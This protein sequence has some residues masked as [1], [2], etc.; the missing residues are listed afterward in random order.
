MLFALHAVLL[1]LFALDP[2]ESSRGFWIEAAVG[3]GFLGMGFFIIQFA[4]TGRFPRIAPGYGS[5]IVLQFHRYA[6]IAGVILILLHPVLLIAA[7]PAYLRFFDPSENLFRALGM[8]AVTFALVGILVSSAWGVPSF[9]TYEQWRLIHAAFALALVGIGM[10][11]GLQVG[12]YLD[13]LWKQI[14]WVVMVGIA[15]ILLAEVRFFRPLRMRRF[16]YRVASVSPERGNTFTLELEPDGHDGMPFKAGQFAWISVGQSPFQ[17]QQNPFSIASAEGDTRLR[18]TAAVAG[19]FTSTW[20]QIQ[21]GTPAWVDGAY[22]SFT[23]LDG[24]KGFYFIAGGTG[25]VP[26]MSILQTMKKR[27]D[28][29]PVTLLYGNPSLKEV[30][31]FE[32]LKSLQQELNLRVIHFLEDGAPDED[33]FEEGFITRE[34]IDR[35]MPNDENRYSYYTCGPAPL[36]DIAETSLREMGVDWRRIIP[37]RFDII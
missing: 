34:H 28:L 12:H 6:G 11:H 20:H 14:V 10:V 15:L 22:G 1:I 30:V 5:D 35:Y 16:P 25:I 26:V 23:L 9:L 3:L 36:M 24:A 31:Y 2:P 32:A 13:T 8:I 18:F 29:R 19:D 27:N 4:T 21:P 7:D 33:G 37:E 17:L